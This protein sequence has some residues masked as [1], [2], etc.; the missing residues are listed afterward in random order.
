MPA[1]R[2]KWYLLIGSILGILCCG[3]GCVS[4]AKNLGT[5]NSS[6]KFPIRTLS[7]QIEQ[8]QREELFVQLQSFSKKHNLEFHLSFYD[9]KRVFFVEMYGEK[10]HILA[11]PIPGAPEK[12]DID[13]YEEDPTN[14]PAQ[15]VVDK[16]FSNLKSFI[17]E[18]PNVTITEEQ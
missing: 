5:K 6:E 12:I 9:N 17:S 8:D 11:Q 1:K 13:L 18:I 3:F 4:I 10:F 16:L 15:E 14:P 7:I 2:A